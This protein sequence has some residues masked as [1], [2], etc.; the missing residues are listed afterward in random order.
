MVDNP[1]TLPNAY[2]DEE[3]TIPFQANKTSSS[4]C[5][6]TLTDPSGKYDRTNGGRTGR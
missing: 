2:V 4:A 3:Y 5:Q 1:L 6:S